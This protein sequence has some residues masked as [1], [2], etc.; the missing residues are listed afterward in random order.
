M[1]ASD[2]YIHS[3]FR[4]NGKSF[5]YDEMLS[6]AN[7]LSNK[8]SFYEQSIGNF[9]A[10]WFSNSPLI[11]LTTSG[12]T[13]SPK[14]VTISKK[15]MLASAQATGKYL[16][17]QS[18][19]T[20]LLCLPANFIG[21]KMMLVRAWLLGLQL[22]IT[23]PSPNPLQNSSDVFDFCAMTPHQLG[24]SLSSLSRIKTLIVGGA[25]VSERLIQQIQ[26]ASTHVF[27]T[28]GMTETVSHIALKKINGTQKN[29]CFQTLPNVTVSI[30]DRGCLVIDASTILPNPVTTNDLVRL[31][32][33]NS[34]EWLGRVDRVVNSGGI[35]LIP[36]QIEK[37]LAYLF[38]Q[39]FF[40]TGVPDNEYGEKLV[41]IVEGEASEYTVKELKESRLLPSLHLPKSI[42]I[43]SKFQE[44]QSGKIDRLATVDLL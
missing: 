24:Y 44:T 32:A 23:K 25:P 29:N 6:L 20:A 19:M 11:N 13:G 42:F 12:S 26:S 17:L 28:Y 40:V 1:T 5:S 16:E 33:S 37:S 10:D 27:E 15:A 2:H 31:H 35:K 9:I 4:L 21:G 7:D 18:G 41:L 36:E 8:K 22:T 43:I 34:F 14:T 39:R 30:D 38:T 3:D